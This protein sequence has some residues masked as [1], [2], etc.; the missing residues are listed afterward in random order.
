MEQAALGQVTVGI[1]MALVPFL[2]IA[3][4]LALSEHLR[5]REEVRVNRQIAVTDALHRE[6]GAVAAPEVRRDWLG[7]WTV[8]VAVPFDQEDTVAAVARI[9]HDFFATFHPRDVRR[10][11]VL[12][13]PRERTPRRHLR[14]SSVSRMAA[15]DLSRVA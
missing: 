7:G 1:A 12:L 6:L 15:G 8:S 2:A 3:G 14:P 10:L 11:R 5:R 13:I 9:V 4:L